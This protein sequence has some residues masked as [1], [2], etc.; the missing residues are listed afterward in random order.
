MR[1]QRFIPVIGI[2][3]FLYILWN[4]DLQRI[5]QSMQSIDVALL[6]LA[7]SMTV[8]IVLIK[9][10]KWNI[11]VKSCGIDQSL[12]S[13][14]SSWIVGFSIGMITPGR[15]GDLSRA[16][17]L[18]GKAS[19][20]TGLTTVVID[21]LIDI[22]VL[23]VFAI[24]GLAFLVTTYTLGNIFFPLFAIFIMLILL[25]FAFT[26]KGFVVFILRP[27]FSRLVP[28]RYKPKLDSVFRE[29]YR[30]I[31]I[32]KRAKFSVAISTLLCIIVWVMAIVQ[33]YIISLSLGLDISYSF[34]SMIVPLTILLDAL[35]ISFSGLGTRDAAMIYFLSL[36]GLAAESAVAFSIMILIVNYVLVGIV[37]M[38]LWAKSPINSRGPE[39]YN[40]HARAGGLQYT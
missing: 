4:M 29:F 33:Y 11:L 25:A 26:R 17:Y 39:H 21:R 15:L 32:M 30:G 34:L 20:G 12:R 27:V 7:V 9:A 38:I 13:S 31:S 35:P 10:I 36:I 22:I 5:M 37:G 40:Q 6:L 24:A 14:V 23:F 3:I 8:P 1:L 16:Y 19:L 28:A 18:R 2:V